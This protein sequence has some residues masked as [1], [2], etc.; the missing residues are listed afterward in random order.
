MGIGVS[1]LFIIQQAGDIFFDF[2]IMFNSLVHQVNPVSHP[3]SCLQSTC[4]MPAAYHPIYM[5]ITKSGLT[6]FWKG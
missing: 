5:M 4:G 2:M 1:P 6:P 3:S